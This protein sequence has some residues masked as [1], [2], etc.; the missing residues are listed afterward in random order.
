MLSK[1][2]I[3]GLCVIDVLMF[4][5]A[6]GDVDERGVEGRYAVREDQ[7]IEF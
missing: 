1:L 4:D 2:G 3:C 7:Q 6:V 5:D